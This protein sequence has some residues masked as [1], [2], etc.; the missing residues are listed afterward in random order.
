MQ[1]HVH[2]GVHVHRVETIYGGQIVRQLLT[3][4][5]HVFSRSDQGAAGRV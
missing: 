2:Q 4:E 3:H 1:V 5:T